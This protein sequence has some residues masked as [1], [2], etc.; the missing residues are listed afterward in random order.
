ML[1]PLPVFGRR[2][3][4]QWIDLIFTSPTRW[5]RQ[6]FLPNQPDFDGFFTDSLNYVLLLFLG[7]VIALFLFALLAKL[8][9]A[10]KIQVL[11]YANKALIY[12]LAWIFLV[13][14]FSKILGQQFPDLS[15]MPFENQTENRDILFWAWIGAHPTVVFVLGT[16]EISIALLLFI[17]KTRPLALL[18]FATS[19]FVILFVNLYFHIGVLIFSLVLLAAAGIAFWNN[20]A[21]ITPKKVLPKNIKKAIHLF[22]ALGLLILS[23][24]QNTP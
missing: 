22:I 1:T 14:G 24:Y 8:S 9:D 21:P 12:W 10:I 17:K 19:M 6:T 4:N 2:A 16:L 7:F 15:D 13:Y 5:L 18:L 20:N 3:L 11:Y 23:A